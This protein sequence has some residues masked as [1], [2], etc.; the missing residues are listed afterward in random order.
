MAMLTRDELNPYPPEGLEPVL[1]TAGADLSA[2]LSPAPER[3]AEPSAKSWRWLLV[4]LN[5]CALLGGVGAAAFVWMLSLPPAP[6][7]DRLTA[8]SAD[9]ERIYCAEAA[10]RT[11]ELPKL[12]AS[13][14]S[15]DHWTED[16]PLYR[17]AQRLVNEWS[18]QLLVIARQ[19]MRTGDL[20]G[21]MAIVNEIPTS[22][23]V[24]REVQE[25]V[26]QWTALWSEA[27][28]IR[29]AAL[30]AMEQQ[31]WSAA[32]S[33][34]R[35]LEYV[36]HDYWR[37]EQVIELSRRLWQERQGRNYEKE[38]LALAA[39]GKPT[40]FQAAMA[41]VAKI[42]ADTFAR[43]SMQPTLNQWSDALLT[44]GLQHWRE[45]KL[46]EAI[47]LAELVVPNAE[48]RLAAEHLIRLSESRQLALS[49]VTHWHT[50]AR[51]LI[52]LREAIAAA[53]TIPQGSAVYAQAQ[54]SITS[55]QQQ[56]A[57]L[58]QL[59]RAQATAALG[60]V[61][62]LQM[63]IAQANAV[64]PSHLRRVQAQTLAAHWR[65]EIQRR[66]D[67]PLL[68]RARRLA[69]PGTVSALK[70]AI[71]QAERVPMGRALRG[72]AQGLAYEW[73]QQIQTIE[74]E[75]FL[76]MAQSLARQG[77]LHDAI[78]TASVIRPDRAL[79]PRAT[80]AIRSWQAQIRAAEETRIRR[81]QQERAAQQR[82]SE[83]E[84]S[85]PVPFTAIPD[86][87]PQAE[88]DTVAPRQ[89]RLPAAS[90]PSPSPATPPP[91]LQQGV[92]PLYAPP[93]PLEGDRPPIYPRSES[94]GAVVTPA[95]A[96]PTE[97]PPIFSSPSSPRVL[98]A[99]VASPTRTAPAVD[100][101]AAPS[102][103]PASQA[104]PQ[105]AVPP[106]VILQEVPPA[107]FPAEPRV[108]SQPTESAPST[109]HFTESGLT[110]IH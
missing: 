82:A 40:D 76:R 96:A 58:Q 52:S 46:T 7:C 51:H 67:A 35:E 61:E 83:A 47:A 41:V 62:S 30:E 93:Q 72:E 106:P 54:D 68:Q 74:D 8:L 45:A 12:M 92:E 25:S 44:Q 56:L 22:T 19:K 57:D 97:A 33:T 100:A 103:P 108:R 75:P 73:T 91:V 10:A 84:A 102:V 15:L 42:E 18:A 79:H 26:A 87:Q 16:Q 17:E 101:P 80:G 55:W 37:V 105:P 63:A 88:P 24:Y 90:S 13:I 23:P 69:E 110:P 89:F 21:A 95:P 60:T 66:E 71:A 1:A 14:N 53:Q 77:K 109:S 94:P 9:M 78:R 107:V 2:G 38:A 65:N 48:R 98:D 43:R 29:T 31:N 85:A 34:I 5:L 3:S 28:G 59:Q 20:D 36:P 64:E 49:T 70:G 81:V 11:G 99:P 86:P 39:S 4:G 32:L 50:S 6:E 27:E 104:Q